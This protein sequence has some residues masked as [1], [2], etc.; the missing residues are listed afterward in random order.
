MTKEAEDQIRT[1]SQTSKT[2]ID[3]RKQ[4]IFMCWGGILDLL[5]DVAMAKFLWVDSIEFKGDRWEMTDYK[6]GTIKKKAASTTLTKNY[7]LK[8]LRINKVLYVAQ[9]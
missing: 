6:K 4:F 7:T 5:F 9:E 8:K 1:V 2:A 3:N